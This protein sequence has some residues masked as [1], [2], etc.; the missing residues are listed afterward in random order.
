MSLFRKPKKTIQRRVFSIGL[1]EHGEDEEIVVGNSDRHKDKSE[2]KPKDGGK[3]HKKNSLLSFD[4][5]GMHFVVL[6]MR[7]EHQ[8]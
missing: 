5:E 8:V 2:K 4:D 6:N 3:S 1:D 7:L